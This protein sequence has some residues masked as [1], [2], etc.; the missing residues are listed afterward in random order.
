MITVREQ[1]DYSTFHGL[2]SDISL[3]KHIPNKYGY[4]CGRYVQNGDELII[5]DNG[6]KYLFDEVNKRWLSCSSSTTS[7]GSSPSGSSP[8]YTDKEYIV[9]DTTLQCMTAS[10][11]FT[12]N[13]ENT[14]FTLRDLHDKKIVKITF[15]STTSFTNGAIAFLDDSGNVAL[16]LTN[17]NGTYGRGQVTGATIIDNVSFKSMRFESNGST[18]N[19]YLLLEVAKIN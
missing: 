19:T 16:K 10:S 14:I 18:G 7:S 1:I 4:L 5:M 2:S 6:S 15:L 13:A 8:Q 17:K 12:P 11:D 9:V 3:N